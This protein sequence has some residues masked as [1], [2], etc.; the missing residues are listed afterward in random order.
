MENTLLKTKEDAIQFLIWVEFLKTELLEKGIN[1]LQPTRNEYCCLGV[2]CVLFSEDLPVHVRLPGN[3][4]DEAGY[5]TPQWLVDV[6]RDFHVKTGHAL[7]VLNDDVEYTH[8]E[9]AYI[10]EEVYKEELENIDWS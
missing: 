2:G 9:I 3:Y 8:A 7:I 6:D 10:L 5:P 4:P 1:E